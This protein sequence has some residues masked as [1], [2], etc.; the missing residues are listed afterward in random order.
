MS[1]SRPEPRREH[2]ARQIPP[3]PN[4]RGSVPYTRFIP[5]EELQGFSAWTPDAFGGAASFAQ[6]VQQ[7]PVGLQVTV[8][9]VLLKQPVRQAEPAANSTTIHQRQV[10]V[11]TSRS[12]R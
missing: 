2:A 11:W 7:N 12:P 9:Q 10:P 3:P 8:G 5:R 6:P 1:S 4:S